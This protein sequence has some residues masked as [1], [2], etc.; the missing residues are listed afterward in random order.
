MPLFAITF[1]LGIIALQ[2]FQ[3]LPSIKWMLLLL[4]CI[5]PKKFRIFAGFIL[6]FT[7]CLW[8]A[9][10]HLSWQL[11][12]SI[13][14]KKITIT[15]TI[16]SIPDS[17]ERQTKFILSLDES[18]VRVKLSWRGVHPELHVGDRWKYWVKLKRIHG[19]L[20]PAGFDYEAWAFLENIRAQGY[21]INNKINHLIESHW[22]SHPIHR[23]REHIKNKI[24]LALPQSNTSPWIYAL[25][26]GE[27]NKIAAKNWEILRNTGTNHLM[28]IAGLHIGFMA[29]FAYLITIFF[30]RRTQL[31]LILPA[32]HAGAIAS[33]FMALVY[34][35][36]AGFAIPTQ[37]ACIMLSVCLITILLRRKIIAWRAWSTALL[38]VLLLNP[39]SVLS[40]SFWLSFGSVALI[41]YGIAGRLSPHNL[42][43]KW[44]RTQWVIAIGLIPLSII[45]FQQSSLVSFAANSIA[46]PW[47]G[48]LILPFCF[49]GCVFVL[50][51]TKL[52]GIFL[53]L[54][55]KS[56]AIL[57]II[58]TWFAQLHFAAWSQ[59]IL[60]HW[61]IILGCIGVIILLVPAGFPGRLF[62]FIFLLPIFFCP[63]PQVKQNEFKFTV[64]DVGQG[65]AAVVQTKNHL[66]I[67]DAGPKLSDSFDMGENVVAPF[68]HSL[69]VKTIDMLVVSHGDNDHR[70]G[71]YALL[72]QFRVRSIKTS[73][74]EKFY[75]FNADYCLRGN[76]WQWDGIEFEFLHPTVQQ[77]KLNNNSSCVLRVGRGK[78]AVLLPGDIEKSAEKDLIEKNI[79]NSSVAILIAPHH[80]SKTSAESQFITTLHPTYVI[81]PIGYRNRYHFPHEKVIEMYN[82][83]NVNKLD[84]VNSGAIQ[85][86]LNLNGII[87]GPDAYRKQNQKYWNDA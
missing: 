5:I 23:L 74:P 20:N 67:F 27:R 59:V 29:G 50:F 41:I 69:G 30:W 64:L 32:Q 42:W 33:L 62:G 3:T 78:S 24:N 1:L 36:L 47:V 71:T 51:S 73:V 65:L 28:A 21:V 48:F 22:Y 56:L 70:G 9:T 52:G 46:I 53:L 72:K 18:H 10:S 58:L 85:F 61:I 12:Q 80:G 83:L 82:Q 43:W 86:E 6:G 26:I 76:S 63:F 34:S 57:W 60:N 16:V 17:D 2:F 11:P 68:V 15:G 25:I 55:D 35:A 49:L 14:G 40:A 66:L 8:F 39:L 87:K 79:I 75:G 31:S 84:T 81:F 44:G 4:V 37:R 19:N 54:A 38:I 7:W 13:E 77:L 45:L